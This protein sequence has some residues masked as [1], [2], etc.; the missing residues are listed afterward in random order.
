MS[1]FVEYYRQ[2][3]Y[4]IPAL[5]GKGDIYTFITNRSKAMSIIRKPKLNAENSA[6]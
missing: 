3:D 5:Y 1:R 6:M 4:I 2:I